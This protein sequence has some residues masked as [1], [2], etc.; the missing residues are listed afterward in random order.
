MKRQAVPA[1]F[2][3]DILDQL[4]AHE[5]GTALAELPL[6]TVWVRLDRGMVSVMDQPT[7]STRD[8]WEV[9]LDARQEYNTT[10]IIMESLDGGQ[11]WEQH[12][13][14]RHRGRGMLA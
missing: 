1:E 6:Y 9:A 4:F 13:M 7:D 10:T 2:P 3:V 14:F 11:S 12:M 5:I 8:A